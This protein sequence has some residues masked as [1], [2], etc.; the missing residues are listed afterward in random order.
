VEP[1]TI[2]SDGDYLIDVMGIPGDTYSYGF[3][4]PSTIAT[5]QQIEITQPFYLVSTGIAADS[6]LAGST[7]LRPDGRPII[8]FH[9][10]DWIFL[11]I[12]SDPFCDSH[13]TLELTYVSFVTNVKTLITSN[14]I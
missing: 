6:N 1:F 5:N 7:A 4:A 10:E 9:E 3:V 11:R 2:P 13:D 8:A 12:C 14:G